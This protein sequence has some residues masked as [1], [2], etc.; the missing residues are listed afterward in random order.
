MQLPH[1]PR[2]RTPI[3]AAWGASIIRYLRA[4]T[5]RSS[6]QVRVSTTPGGTYFEPLARPQPGGSA[7]AEPAL[8]PFQIVKVADG[9]P[10]QV[11]VRP[12]RVFLPGALGATTASTATIAGLDTDL[13]VV[14]D[15]IVFLK[16]G[17]GS[18]YEV[19][20]ESLAALEEWEDWPALFSEDSSS[21]PV[22]TAWYILLGYVGALP[23][24]PAPGFAITIDDT[25]LWLHQAVHTHLRIFDLCH[26]GRPIRQPLPWGAPLPV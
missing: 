1:E 22:Q 14:A 8:H 17:G 9:D 7:A 12:G 3:D 4:I 6:A 26:N 19:F 15:S 23:A 24:T 13:E 11:Q 18:S 10:A 5:P 2:H 16:W 25:P 20:A 21:P